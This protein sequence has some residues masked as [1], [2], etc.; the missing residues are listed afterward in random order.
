MKKMLCM[1]L[2]ISLLISFWC[3]GSLSE[4]SQPAV[5]SSLADLG[6]A[7]V[8]NDATAELKVGEVTVTV[9]HSKWGTPSVASRANSITV[10]FMLFET[11]QITISYYPDN[12]V[13]VVRAAKGRE[14]LTYYL[15]DSVTCNYLFSS[16]QESTQ[17]IMNEV[18][19]GSDAEDVLLAP[20]SLLIPKVLRDS[21]GE[22]NANLD[23]LFSLPY[24]VNTKD[25][26]SLI[27]LGFVFTKNDNGSL[28]L[29][30]QKTPQYYSVEVYNPQ[31]GQSDEA[32]FVR[33]FTP[34]GA[35]RYGLVI[36][37]YS[38]KKTYDA[39]IDDR[40]DGSGAE[41]EYAVRTKEYRD[42]WC[43]MKDISVEEYFRNAYNEPA[44]ADV[45]QH[46]IDI[47]EQYISQTFGMS[48]DELYALPTGE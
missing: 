23:M 17:Q 43:S 31:W 26:P 10:D 41:F 5:A 29:F 24:N 35:D 15:Y 33:F 16:D 42:I 44:I 6:F 38:A 20:I 28:Y 2:T 4:A 8:D 19:D 7:F 37:Y 40:S 30:A 3:C 27:N 25:E 36:T 21:V 46:S 12:K 48:I 39:G 13:Y 14:P 32:G 18:M 11:Y 47:M 34:L 1:L 9:C 22:S 45:Y